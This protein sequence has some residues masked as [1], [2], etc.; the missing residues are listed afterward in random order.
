MTF[1][2]QQSMELNGGRNN[3]ETSIVVSCPIIYRTLPFGQCL[4]CQLPH[5]SKTVNST[6]HYM[7][8]KNTWN[9]PHVS[10]LSFIFNPFNVVQLFFCDIVY[11]LLA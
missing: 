2:T 11:I 1:D 4:L 7:P 8:I 10:Y 5:Q 9:H 3:S 6:D